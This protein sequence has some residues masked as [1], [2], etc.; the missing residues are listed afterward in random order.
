MAIMKV[1]LL[2]V[3][4]HSLWI[5]PIQKEKTKGE[6]QNYEEN[7]DSVGGL[8]LDGL[9]HCLVSALDVLCGCD[10]VCLHQLHT[11]CLLEDFLSKYVLQLSYLDN[12]ALHLVHLIIEGIQVLQQPL[13][14]QLH[15]G[16]LL[17][18][19]LLLLL[20]LPP[21]AGGLEATGCSRYSLFLQLLEGW[22]LLVY[23]VYSNSYILY[24]FHNVLKNVLV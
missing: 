19:K 8:I 4:Y 18:A 17:L 12:L 16:S 23:I 9:P 14:L 7:V 24:C 10:G 6:N 5:I 22:G 20:A 2:I 1:L 21:V 15:H 3:Y 13:I 11:L